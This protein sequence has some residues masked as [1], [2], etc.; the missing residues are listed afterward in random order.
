MTSSKADM[1]LLGIGHPIDSCVSP[2]R[3]TPVLIR[4]APDRAQHIAH[5]LAQ[6]QEYVARVAALRHSLQSDP[7]VGHTDRHYM[8]YISQA[9]TPPTCT[10]SAMHARTTPFSSCRKRHRVGRMSNP[11][12]SKI[13]CVLARHLN[14]MQHDVRP[15]AKRDR[16]LERP[17]C[18][19]SRLPCCS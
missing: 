12:D 10:K 13:G 7:Q 11:T 16:L 15:G 4:P 1:R 3:H 2:P 17:K 6:H 19:Y 9:L 14:M 8:C 18:I 5:L